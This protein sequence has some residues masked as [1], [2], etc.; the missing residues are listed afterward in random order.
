MRSV[1]HSPVAVGTDGSERATRAIEVAAAEAAYRAAPL[2]IVHAYQTPMLVYAAPIGM[3][4]PTPMQATG[5]TDTDHAI[6]AEARARVLRRYPTVDVT[7]A[8]VHDTPARALLDAANDAQLV[9]VGGCGVGAVA[10]LLLGSV[11]AH[12]ATHAHAP[13]LV[14]RGAAGKPLDAPIVLGLDPADPSTDAIAFA[15]DVAAK[16]QVPLHAV[17]VGAV[18]PDAVVDTLGPWQDKYPDV[19]LTTRVIPEGG[20]ASVLIGFSTTAAMV[21]VGSHQHGRLRSQLLGSVGYA[22]IHHGHSPIAIVHPY[23][24]RSPAAIR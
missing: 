8:L 11:S 16:R 13:V 12:V 22:L 4:P 14:V 24:D 18:P 20:P 23:N 2:R 15:F 19:Q 9:V 10:S 3:A 5:P 17:Y 6:L 1:N 7:T 21:V